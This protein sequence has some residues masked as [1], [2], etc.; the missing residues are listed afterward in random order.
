MDSLD[1]IEL[2]KVCIDLKLLEA[3][4]RVR[5]YVMRSPSKSS[6]V[7]FNGLVEMYCKLGDTRTAK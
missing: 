5:E 6:S 2:L 1:N 4:K 7:V 3:G